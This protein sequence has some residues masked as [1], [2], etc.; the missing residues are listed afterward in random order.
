[1]NDVQIYL[2]ED[3]DISAEIVHKARDL[4]RLIPL[5]NEPERVLDLTI[6]YLLERIVPQIEQRQR[7]N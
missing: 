6:S 4:T 3:D 7:S 5:A 1:M 2:I